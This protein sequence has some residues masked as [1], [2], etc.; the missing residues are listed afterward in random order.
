MKCGDKGFLPE[1]HEIPVFPPI[2]R[3]PPFLKTSVGEKD[4]HIRVLADFMVTDGIK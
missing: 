3:C 2:S 4:P 1:F